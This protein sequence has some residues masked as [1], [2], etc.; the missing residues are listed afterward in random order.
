MKGA[1]EK[2]KAIGGRLGALLL[3]ALC[4]ATPVLGQTAAQQRKF[5]LAT[6]YRSARFQAEARR[7]FDQYGLWARPRNAD[8]LP[9]VGDTLLAWIDRYIVRP[10]EPAPEPELPPI[11]ITSVTLVPRLQRGWFEEEFK[12]T[13]WAYLGSAGRFTPLDTMR[14]HRLRALLEAKHGPP[15]VTLSELDLSK[16]LKPDDYIQFE[17]YFVLNDSI[18]LI[19]T[20]PNGPFDRGLVVASDRAYR[21][22]LFDLRQAFL[23]AILLEEATPYVDYFYRYSDRS[24][25]LVGFDGRR[26]FRERIRRPTPIGRRPLLS[27]LEN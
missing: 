21:A 13:K 27:D 23:G 17:Y 5:D 1:G 11:E 10:E 3:L 25:Y 24:W 4:L 12:K 14:T 9:Y 2:R 19:V 6:A 7:I 22:R 26:F 15:S 20:D 8:H 18:P 16:D